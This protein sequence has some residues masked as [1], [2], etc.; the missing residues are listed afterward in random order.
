MVYI[1]LC[2]V[3]KNITMSTDQVSYIPEKNKIKYC[4]FN[5]IRGI[6]ILVDLVDS[7]KTDN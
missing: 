1:V 5:I 3:I 6:Q 4:K 2:T 7:I